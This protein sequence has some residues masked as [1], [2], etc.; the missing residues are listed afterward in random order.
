VGRRSQRAQR[1]LGGIA[2]SLAV[3][4]VIWLPL[5]VAGIAPFVLELPGESRLRVHAAAAVLSLLIA[6]WGYWER[7]S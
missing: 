1:V 6:A 4:F 7:E 2:L 3:V 5:G